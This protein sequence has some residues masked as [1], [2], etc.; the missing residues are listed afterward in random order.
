VCEHCPWVNFGQTEDIMRATAEEEVLEDALV[1]FGIYLRVCVNIALRSGGRE[2]GRGKPLW[3]DLFEPRK[4]EGGEQEGTETL[5]HKTYLV[6]IVLNLCVWV[7]QVTI[8][9]HHLVEHG[10]LRVHP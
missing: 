7:V 2:G 4:R 10:P 9:A 3:A 5:H 1:V 8:H 6:A